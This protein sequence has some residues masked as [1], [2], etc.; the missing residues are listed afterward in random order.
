[1]KHSRYDAV[2]VG[3]GPN[4][5]A[6]AIEMARAG[7]ST[8]LLEAEESIGG[9]ARS[10]PLTLPGFVHDVGAAIFPLTLASPFM[11]TVPL[12]DYGVRWVYPPAAV[13][14]PL[15]D[16]T[17]VLLHSSVEQTATG[18]GVDAARYRRLMEPLVAGW[19]NVSETLLGPP[20]FPRHPLAFAHFGLLAIWPATVESRVLFRGKQARALFAGLA[21]HSV[22]PLSRPLTSAFALTFAITGH[23]VG[24][25]FPR[26]GTQT[27]SDAL[28]RYFES[29]GGEIVT[30]TRVESMSGIPPARTVL[31]DLT[32][33][34][35]EQIAGNTLPDRFRRGLRRYRYGPGVFKVDYALS[36]PV[37]WT[38]AEVGSAATVHLGGTLSEIATS[39]RDVARGGHP[40]RPFVLAAQQSLF[41]P[42]RAPDGKHTLWA[43]CHVPNGSTIDMS[44]RIEEQIE[45]FAPGFRDLILAR[46]T[47]SPADL[48]RFDANLV[49]GDISGGSQAAWQVM[50]RSVVNLSP[51]KLPGRGLFM[52]SSAT[53]P[54]G[55]VHGMGGYFA[56]RSALK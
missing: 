46:N 32:P 20:R 12:E 54:G 26:G 22:S 37:P 5:L 18:L 41:D 38:S 25:P 48:E 1:V 6:A 42:S 24:W 33:R 8:L 27:L 21:A 9:A 2:V 45:R 31:L 34:Q 29:L 53:P 56:A 51:Y 43:Y 10:A 44:D 40:E 35:I 14:H 30:G 16:G 17:A 52:C 39:E 47:M 13:A 49:G 19:D 4:G 36:G 3:A 55:G 28:A 23:A 50:R 15:D 7:R 11:R